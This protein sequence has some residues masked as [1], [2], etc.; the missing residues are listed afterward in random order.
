MKTS[1][2]LISGS[3]GNVAVGF[4]ADRISAAHIDSFKELKDQHVDI[5]GRM[6]HTI[7]MDD[8]PD[9]GGEMSIVER[10]VV[11]RNVTTSQLAFP[12][13]AD[14]PVRV[15]ETLLKAGQVNGR[16]EITLKVVHSF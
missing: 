8:L 2:G 13:P 3:I 16:I 4:V 9:V 10:L 15:D 6:H 12:N 1:W 14:S 11:P 5:I 7:S